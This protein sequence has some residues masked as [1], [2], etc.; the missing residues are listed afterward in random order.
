M[1]LE[2]HSE[3]VFRLSSKC[4]PKMSP[5][6]ETKYQMFS[7]VKQFQFILFF[8]FFIQTHIIFSSAEFSGRSLKYIITHP[9]STF[10]NKFSFYQ[11]FLACKI[12]KRVRMI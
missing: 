4:V 5:Q 2:N 12:T 11:A 8:I 10:S 3:N 6:L 7:N 9:L 1:M